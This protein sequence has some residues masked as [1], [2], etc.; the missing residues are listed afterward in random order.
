M[1]TVLAL[2]V[3]YNQG[4]QNMY[5]PPAPAPAPPALPGYYQG[6]PPSNF[7]PPPSAPSQPN[8]PTPST[9]PPSVT[10]DQ[11]SECLN[12]TCQDDL[13]ECIPQC[14]EPPKPKDKKKHKDDD[15]DKDTPKPSK[16]E[17]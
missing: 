17:A 7:P 13:D 15:N 12:K 6:A 2:P 14:M 3:N 11:F 16:E 10:W 9:L 8:Y 5:Y 1:T 4:Y